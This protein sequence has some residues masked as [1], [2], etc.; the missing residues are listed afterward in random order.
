MVEVLFVLG[1]VVGGAVEVV[2][3]VVWVEV[4]GLKRDIG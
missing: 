4:V 3:Y 2:V 1:M